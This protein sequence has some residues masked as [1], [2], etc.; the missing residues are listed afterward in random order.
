MYR[1]VLVWIILLAGAWWWFAPNSSRVSMP[2]ALGD[3]LA[4]HFVPLQATS[5]QDV[6]LQTTLPLGMKP[7]RLP[8]VEITP[9][10]GFNIDAKVLSRENYRFDKVAAVSHVDLAVGWGPLAE[11]FT[12]AQFKFR[13]KKR[14]GYYRWKVDMPPSLSQEEIVKS[15]ANMH[16]I[17]STISVA[18]EIAKVK[19][20]D[21]IHIDGWL[22]QAKHD[23]GW[24][25]KSS[26]SR[27]DTGVGA[28]EVIWVCNINIQEGIKR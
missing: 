19:K 10:A 8:H 6:P 16:L 4:C 15:F 5:I 17:P 20:G 2:S 7:W 27:E 14:Y 1:L 9:L 25:I 3:G 11:D 23:N 12:A 28:C 24:L 13:Q 18:H 26:L 22:V 21:V